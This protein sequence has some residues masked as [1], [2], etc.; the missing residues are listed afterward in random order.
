MRSARNGAFALLLAFACA[1]SA[2]AA[3]TGFCDYFPLT[4]TC[5]AI[6]SSAACTGDCAWSAGDSECQVASSGISAVL[7]A[8]DS[9]SQAFTTQVVGCLGNSGDATTCVADTNCEY[10]AAS[11]D[12]SATEAF[13]LSKYAT[14]PASTSAGASITGFC[15]Y[16]P[17]TVTCAAITSSAACTGDCTWNAGDTECEAPASGILPV[18]TAMD[19]ISQAFTTQF[20]ACTADNGDATNCAA[21][22]NCEYDASSGEC[23]VKEAF[24]LSKYATCPASPSP[25]A[26]SPASTSAGERTRVGFVAPATAFV[27]ATALAALA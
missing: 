14:C 9:T 17:L 13:T 6:T 18:L 15:D 11:G 24:A 10:D 20:L 25:P 12:C 23:S 7:T 3:V 22:T 2:R 5:V 27:A 19:S 1:S 26:P 21:D 8:T 16:F 4:M